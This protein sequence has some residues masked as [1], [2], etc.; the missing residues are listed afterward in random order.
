[1]TAFERARLTTEAYFMGRL[2]SYPAALQ[3]TFFSNAADLLGKLRPM[4]LQ[5][6]LEGVELLA[7]PATHSVVLSGWRPL[8][9]TDRTAV[10]SPSLHA[11]CQACDLFDP[12]KHLAVWLSVHQMLAAEQGLWFLDFALTP[13]WV[14]AQ[15][16]PAGDAQR[17]FR[18]RQEETA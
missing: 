11:S 12:F 15:T 9:T 14:H 13:D 10:L 8:G 17:I 4:L 5:A 3:T 6:S 7:H 18:P 16:K 2:R 1:M